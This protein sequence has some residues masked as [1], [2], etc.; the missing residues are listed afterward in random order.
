MQSGLLTQALE[1]ALI[2]ILSP[3]IYVNE[4]IIASVIKQRYQ[5]TQL[6]EIAVGQYQIS[7]SCHTWSLYVPGTGLS[8]YV[9]FWKNASA[10][11]RLYS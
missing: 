11:M 3:G 1:Q 6:A 7:V 10:T 4:D 2:K 5:T 9:V 8:L